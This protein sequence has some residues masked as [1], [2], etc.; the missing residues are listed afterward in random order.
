MAIQYHNDNTNRI[1]FCGAAILN[2]LWIL[3]SADCVHNA[4]SIRADLGHVNINRPAIS[5]FPDTSFI[6]PQ[7]NPNRFIN[8]LALLRMPTNRPISFPS[9]PRPA[10]WPIRL[11]ARRQQTTTFENTD[12]FFTGYGYTSASKLLCDLIWKI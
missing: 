6:H 4:R 2:E 1:T 11:P 9:G 10:F 7:Y 3:T 5:V 12:A 8:N